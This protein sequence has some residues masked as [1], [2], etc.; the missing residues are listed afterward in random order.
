MGGTCRPLNFKGGVCRILNVGV[1][2]LK[3]KFLGVGLSES[4]M[5]GVQNSTF[6]RGEAFRIFNP[7]V[8]SQIRSLILSGRGLPQEK[9]L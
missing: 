9:Q 4:E 5:L 2:L 6:F 8:L 1:G 7:S 3:L